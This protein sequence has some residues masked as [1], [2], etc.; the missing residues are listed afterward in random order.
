MISYRRLQDK[1]S[2][3]AGPIEVVK[4]IVRND[5]VLG[6]YAGMEATFWRCTFFLA[7]HMAVALNTFGRHFWWNGGYFGS[8][9]QVRAMMPKAEVYRFSCII[10]L[11]LI[12]VGDQ[13]PQ[14]E[15]FNNFISGSVGGFIGTA[16]NTP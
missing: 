1:S 10:Y 13:S 9:F 5:G 7:F 4:Q 2:T 15:L 16:V 14:G 11:M 8:I 12:V 6:L 3:F